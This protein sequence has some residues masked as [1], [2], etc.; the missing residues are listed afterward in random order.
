MTF[1]Y[2]KKLPLKQPNIDAQDTTWLEL[3]QQCRNN[4]TAR[5]GPTLTQFTLLRWACDAKT[6]GT[7]HDTTQTVGW[8]QWWHITRRDTAWHD[9]IQHRLTAL[10]CCK[11]WCTTWHDPTWHNRKCHQMS[12]T[13]GIL[14]LRVGGGDDQHL[15][16]RV[17]L[18]AAG[19]G[20]F[21]RIAAPPPRHR[22]ALQIGALTQPGR[23][24]AMSQRDL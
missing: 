11:W 10:P 17:I 15:G 2:T 22:A 14:L 19:S 23:R 8:P 12:Q 18:F 9:T 16:V 3:V 24:A 6:N 21:F 7:W 20:S 13:Y 5:Q 1:H 4:K